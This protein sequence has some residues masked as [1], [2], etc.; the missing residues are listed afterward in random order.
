MGYDIFCCNK[1]PVIVSL[2]LFISGRN[3]A[4]TTLKNV[5]RSK[6]PVAWES[7][8]ETQGEISEAPVRLFPYDEISLL[9]C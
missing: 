7:W 8:M 9:R 3:Y 2:K 4:I 5:Q 6:S 1:I